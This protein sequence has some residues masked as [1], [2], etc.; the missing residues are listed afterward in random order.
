MLPGGHRVPHQSRWTPR[1]GSG[2]VMWKAAPPVILSMVRSPRPLT[3]PSQSTV[4]ID[5]LWRATLAIDQA[6]VALRQGAVAVAFLTA[7]DQAYEAVHQLPRG[8]TEQ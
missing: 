1:S 2:E 7:L 5:D 3:L 6:I 8:L 4:M